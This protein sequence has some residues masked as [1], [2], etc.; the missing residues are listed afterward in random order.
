MTS[1]AACRTRRRRPTAPRRERPRRTPGASTTPSTAGRL[2]AR[3]PARGAAAEPRP[4]ASGVDP[5]DGPV[6]ISPRSTRAA[7]HRTRETTTEMPGWIE[8]RQGSRTRRDLPRGTPPDRKRPSARAVPPAER[9]A[10]R[11]ARTR[12]EDRGG[13]ARCRL[14]EPRSR[15]LAPAPGRSCRRRYGAGSILS[16]APSCM[17]VVRYRNPSG[18]CLTSRIR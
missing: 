12:S 2:A 14:T 3:A 13:L 4:R 18:P 5:C 11:S 17:S 15:R 16:T 6:R 1:R 10:G 9:T 8:P 7:R